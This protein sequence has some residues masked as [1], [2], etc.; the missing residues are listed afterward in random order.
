MSNECDP[1]QHVQD[2]I[3]TVHI[4]RGTWQGPASEAPIILTPLER[5]V[6]EISA[7]GDLHALAAARN[8]I[9]QRMQ[10]VICQQMGDDDA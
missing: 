3:T 1:N 6:R 4:G 8:A 10:D 9:S 7:T 2:L 5:L